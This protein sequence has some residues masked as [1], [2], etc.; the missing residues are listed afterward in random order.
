M[1]KTGFFFSSVQASVGTGRRENQPPEWSVF[2]HDVSCV[3][4]RPTVQATLARLSSVLPLART[5][6]RAF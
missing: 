2:L 5:R 6:E 4:R 3:L 1:H